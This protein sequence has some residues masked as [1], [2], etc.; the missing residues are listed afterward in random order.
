MPKI[1]WLIAA[2][3][4]VPAL[5]QKPVRMMVDD[6][7]GADLG[8]W[9][10]SMSP[11]YYKGQEG[12]QGLQIVDDAERGGKVL[13]ANVKWVDPKASEPC[14]ITRFL[15]PPPKKTSVIAVSFWYKVTKAALNPQGGFKVRL[16]TGPRS[17]TDYDVL[18][19][20]PPP[21]NQWRHVTLD[22]SI[23]PNVR[24]IY[25]S[26]WGHIIQLTFRLDDIDDRNADFD[27]YLDDVE[28]TLSEPEK[29]EYTPRTVQRPQDEKLRVLYM[30]HSAAGY[31]GLEEAIRQVDPQA[32]IATQL[33][34]GLHFEF[35]DFPQ[36]PAEVWAYDVFIMLDVDPWVLR[37]EQACAI[38]DAVNSGATFV[39]FGGPNTLH[40]AKDMKA[41]IRGLLPVTY[42]EKAKDVGGGMPVAARE[43][44]LTAG[45]P[46]AGL[47]SVA[48]MHQVEPLPEAQVLWTAGKRPLVVAGPVGQGRTL[49]IN[50]WPRQG[51]ERRGRF[52]SSDLSDDF[53]RQ[54]VRWAAG[55]VPGAYLTEVE[56][57]PQTVVGRQEVGARTKIGG[58][59]ADCAV[60]LLVNGKAVKGTRFTVDPGSFDHVDVPYALELVKGGKVLDRRDA[61]VQAQHPY[62]LEVQWAAQ[63]YCLAPGWPLEF[64][65]QL[66]R[67]DLPEVKADGA[68]V[69]MSFGGQLVDVTG[70]VDTWIYEQKGEKVIHDQLGALEVKAEQTAEGLLPRWHV[71]G[72]CQ[73]GRQSG[74]KW[75]EDPRYLQVERQVR[76]MEDGAVIVETDYEFLADVKV[77]RLPLLV[78]LPCSL[79]GGK[80]FRCEQKE[81]VR[82][83][84]LPAEQG[85]KIFD[86]TGMKFTVETEAG[87]LSIE[88]LNPSL[89]CWLRDLRQYKMSVFRFEI[90]APVAGQEVR[91]GHKY[92]IALRFAGPRPQ[93][94]TAELPSP[95]G[96]KIRAEARPAEGGAVC[97][98]A[99]R[100]AQATTEFRDKLPRLRQG[101]YVLT[102]SLLDGKGQTIVS[103]AAPLQVVAP[104]DRANFYPIMTIIGDNGGG[105]S[106]DDAL[107]RARLDDIWAHGFNCVATMGGIPRWAR[108]GRD[109][110]G[111]R[112]G[113]AE[114][115]AQALGM[116]VFGEYQHYTNLSRDGK[117]SP[118]VHS[119]EYRAALEKHTA[120]Y[121]EA[122]RHMPRL[123]SIKIVDE[124]VVTPKA[125]D[126]CEHC[127]RVFA[128]RYGG[129]LKPLDKLADDPFG[130]WKMA[131]FLGD[132]VADAYRTGMAIKREAGAQWDLLVTYMATGCGF[133]RPLSYQQDG[134][135]WLRQSDRGDFDVY[136]YFYPS[137]QKIRML[138]AAYAMA[139]MRDYA[140]HLSKPWGF[141]VELDD[142]N[143]PYQ[144][145]P[146]EASAECAYTAV[147]HGADYLNSFIHR[148]FGSGTSSRP[149]RWA[150]TGR[151]LPKI[152]RIGPMLCRLKRPRATVAH[153]FP[154]SQQYINNGYPTPTYAWHCLNS[155]FGMIDVYNEEIAREAGLDQYRGLLLLSTTI[156][157][158][159]M[160]P[161]LAEWVK[162]GGVLVYDQ[163][164]EENHKGEP[165]QAPWARETEATTALAGLPDLKYATWKHG[166]GTV[167]HLAFDAN[168]QYK[169]FVE[170]D[171][172]K[173][174]AALRSG[175]SQVLREAGLQALA[176]VRDAQGQME[177]GLRTTADT[178]LLIVVN[179]NSEPSTGEVAVRGLGFAPRFAVDLG[180][181]KPV[182]FAPSGQGA[183]LTV[184]LPGRLATMIALYPRQPKKAEL[185]VTPARVRRGEDL[186]WE[187]ALAGRQGCYLAEFTVRNAQGQEVRRLGKAAATEGGRATVVVPV[188]VNETPGAY[189]VTAEV[190]AAG[191][192]A[193][194]KFAVR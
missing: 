20:E 32:E 162:A 22:T 46:S 33:F 156:L 170:N 57:A 123:L 68:S 149:E 137:S 21:V 76:T 31:Y 1:A 135:D 161:Q 54:V 193:S 62:H 69:R 106:L 2:A 15:D 27:L 141:Y 58:Q 12:K 165:V 147:C 151:E 177:V 95:A 104:L 146:K 168:E 65:V 13:R 144:K 64:D 91:K 90:E 125:M 98:Q 107:L 150:V 80:S 74:E 157:H 75:A 37:W 3:L 148:V 39:F 180:T 192:S 187:L 38:A 153:L 78:T 182:K 117:A 72:I 51:D 66:A 189:T 184:K 116:A 152:R 55:R 179:H 56:L 40:H 120:P 138:T 84:V 186:K 47:G 63:R 185:H 7:E 174:A 118:C 100:P 102:A 23:G 113:A 71:T 29:A 176:S 97:W 6:F 92:S 34:R 126:Y 183:A 101:E 178:A 163:A 171:H 115:Y 128:E 60:R 188:A 109:F 169:D 124:P 194:A 121:L 50:A 73:A 70:F 139:A 172:F 129:E 53:L 17:F 108:I 48:H 136:P 191:L 134:L 81:G 14:W 43:H 89:R 99:T 19:G 30:R 28:F 85:G 83:G 26:L 114:A 142:R 61:M 42:Q 167:I 94:V 24:N 87:P 36:R 88:C 166:K 164:L 52:F 154:V 11:E 111:E 96:A 119:P 131:N 8:K 82:E 44:Y 190:P 16:R 10:S 173:E 159:D 77:Q 122:A 112:A 155:G 145:N 49:F 130:K 25:G 18:R 79:Y 143:W 132:Y 9:Q 41:P 35:F 133:Q 140:T 45:F 59:A 110:G 181:M 160:I 5:A 86:G 127:R 93:G 103:G 4:M 158:A 175:L 105:H 67:R